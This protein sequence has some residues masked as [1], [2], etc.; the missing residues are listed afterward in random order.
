MCICKI[1]GLGISFAYARPMFSFSFFVRRVVLF[2]AIAPA[3]GWGQKISLGVVAGTNAT[4]DFRQSSYTFYGS[5]TTGE[6][7]T[8]TTTVL[9]GSRRL[10]IGPKAE[11]WLPRNW[12]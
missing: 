4:D 2:L 9:P 10:I 7:Y 1:A 8:S 12:A 6:T 11:I 5:L 3:A